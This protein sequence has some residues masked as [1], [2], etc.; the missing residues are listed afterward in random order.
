[1]ARIVAPLAGLR[2][3]DSVM[4]LFRALGWELP[5]REI[6]DQ[7]LVS[8]VT[9]VDRLV[10]SLRSER[11]ALA[12][13]QA[14]LQGV[15][16]IES[17]QSAVKLISD[18]EELRNYLS[19]NLVGYPEFV[20]QSGI[21]SSELPKRLF[22]YL[23][24]TYLKAYRPSYYGWGL[25]AG[26][27]EVKEVEATQYWEPSPKYKLLRVNWSRLLRMLHD[28]KTVWEA[29]GSGSQEGFDSKWFFERFEVL[30][31]CLGIPGGPYR[32]DERAQK[33]LSLGS[34]EVIEIRV[35]LAWAGEWPSSYGEAGFSI[36]PL[37]D[38]ARDRKGIAAI[39]YLF[40]AGGLEQEST[41]VWQ[42][43]LEGAGEVE[44]GLGL[45]FWPPSDIEIQK[46]LFDTESAEGNCRVEF[47]LQRIEREGAPHI[48]FGSS[49]GSRVS[50]AGVGARFLAAIS[51]ADRE[52]VAEIRFDDFTVVVD[53][54]QGDGFVRTILGGIQISN[55]FDLNIGLS[56]KDGLSIGGSSGGEVTIPL[57]REVGP[58]CFDGLVVSVE[59]TTEV[60][61][62]LATSLHAKLGA[63]ETCVTR[64][65][66]KI[67]IHF[68]A[69][70]QGNFGPIDLPGIE[71]Q[72]PS[73]ACL[74]LNTGTI[75][76]SGFLD[77]DQ[78][79]HQ[80]A[81][82]VHLTANG[83]SLN[84]RGLITTQ[85]PG[86]SDGFSLLVI[87]EA[88]FSSPIQLSFGFTL[89]GVGGL[90]ALNRTIDT[91]V[92]RAGLRAGS[93][94][95]ILFPEN[96]IRN[97]DRIISDL[98]SAFP[99]VQDH[100]VLGPMVKLGWGSPRIVQA[101]IGI[102]IEL[103]E[104]VRVVLL[105]QVSVALPR[106]ENAVIELHLDVLGEI[107]FENETLSIDATLN[108]S[109]IYRYP[110]TGD[111]A[112]RWS[113]GDSPAL[114]MSVGGFH[115]R[116]SPPAGFP[117]LRRVALN[118]SS[119][120]DLQIYCDAYQAITSNSI[121]FGSSIALVVRKKGATLEGNLSFDT[122]IYLSPFSF[123]VDIAGNMVA[124]Y[125]GHRLAGVALSMQLSGPRP[126]NAR[127]RAR[128]EILMW[129]VAVRF[130]KSWGPRT[131]LEIEPIDAW[132]LLRDA[133]LRDESWGARLPQG[134]EAIEVLTSQGG[135]GESL[136]VHP[137]G[138][139]EVRQNALPLGIEVQ[140]IGGAPVT[141]K[142][143]FCIDGAEVLC[144]DENADDATK[145]EIA[146]VQ[147][148]FARAQ[149]LVLSD[150]E[151][152]ALPS[153][154]KMQA[155]VTMSPNKI[156]FGSDVK[157]RS[158]GYE[159][160]RIHADGTSSPV[161]LDTSSA[162]TPL[163]E[164]QLRAS[165]AARCAL[166]RTGRRKYAE[167]EKRKFVKLVPEQ[168]QVVSTD[169]SSIQ[170]SVIETEDETRTL[171]V[172]SDASPPAARAGRIEIE[173]A[174]STYLKVNPDQVGKLQI[175]RP[176]RLAK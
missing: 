98:R 52:L 127:G 118:L 26:L 56:N 150:N 147:G 158:V 70:G 145:L 43:G 112:V 132:A 92:L 71:F 165:A 39:P 119:N 33:S 125:R 144:C 11:R 154:E 105:G 82:A 63:F 153:F 45:I 80:Y 108:N 66:M 173:Q 103:P 20:E 72:G 75:S 24:I 162:K 109:R 170:Y 5:S 120:R 134:T 27:V 53:A 136:L 110:L 62:L 142:S 48:I 95:S 174:L 21:L 22:D 12:E 167:R 175:T 151:R 14:S 140:K 41:S 161:S 36:L 86:G 77:H 49:E 17:L 126:W 35:P 28:P 113:W 168:Y 23:T 138:E 84:S 124:R 18:G 10:V 68:P 9:E 94:D 116:F 4:T 111:A 148:D 29:Y 163:L 89:D 93:L 8:L 146:E 123:V 88:Q 137:L 60:S 169:D 106:A 81:G 155:G 102:F 159:T 6:F 115:P 166:R 85:M 59:V 40:G 101:D 114:A 58:V 133:L 122:L 131:R 156:S 31:E 54:S 42:W 141:E 135:G 128:F 104:P 149:F 117:A 30:L 61:I 32:V 37:N 129:D 25:V 69:S 16:L 107:N 78:A 55:S 139:L 38:G 79:K 73:R 19:V 34:G 67:P 76:G 2:D 96:P 74:A 157:N 46:N 7:G 97:A 152:I 90:I 143:L 51:N 64:I 100:V 15:N 44:S 172:S 130:N 13:G 3:G 171:A 99:V 87:I 50:F 160:I 57:H 91:E 164:S 65:G 121:Q 47:H 83:L 1:M 176:A